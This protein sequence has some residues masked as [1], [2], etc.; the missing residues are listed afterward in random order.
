M[1]CSLFIFTVGYVTMYCYVTGINIGNLS[2]MELRM[3]AVFRVLYQGDTGVEER[4]TVGE[5]E[6]RN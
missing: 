5:S 3:I 4:H 1:E 6:E 2:H